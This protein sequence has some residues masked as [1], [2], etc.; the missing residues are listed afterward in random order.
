MEMRLTYCLTSRNN[1]LYKGS[2]QSNTRYK[3][4][5]QHS[6]IIDFIATAK[7]NHCTIDLLIEDKDSFPL[8]EYLLDF[9]SITEFSTGLPALQ[10][11]DAVIL[12]KLSDDAI[13]R[14]NTAVPTFYMVHDAGEQIHPR[15]PHICHKIFCMTD[16]AVKFQ[17][18]GIDNRKLL[19]CHQGVDLERF[20]LKEPVSKAP[21]QPAK[22]KVLLFTRL[23]LQKRTTI[24]AVLNELLKQPRQYSI[25][26]LGDG[27]L[28][29]E[30]SNGYG[31]L[32]TVINHIPCNSI[33]TFLP[34][35]DVV[36]SSARGVM[37][38]CA[39][40]IPA[41]CAGLGYAG[42]VN[43][44]NI[45]HLMIRN[46]TGYGEQAV[47]QDI[48][49]EISQALQVDNTYWRALCKKYFSMD[50]FVQKVLR[51]IKNTRSGK[52]LALDTS[53]H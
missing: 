7:R 37:E 38:A 12:D 35:F 44:E 43:E 48:H 8:Y 29:W 23:T 24:L 3:T 17:S 4:F 11:A 42:L 33:Q 46:L 49:Q 39:S 10:L 31:H 22:I 51:E 1:P 45:P 47:L 41:F 14:I 6:F 15:L 20:S 28:F 53:G 52:S 50:L 40:G 5:G 32:V 16:T 18:A 25:T 13:G 26:L 36:I 2:Y 19:L 9:C 30:I 34:A 21:G 27:E